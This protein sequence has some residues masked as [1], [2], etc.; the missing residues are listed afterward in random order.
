M[1]FTPEMKAWVTDAKAR[2]SLAIGQELDQSIR[3]TLMLSSFLGHPKFFY[4]NPKL[5]VITLKK[6][7]VWLKDPR[8]T[9]AFAKMCAHFLKT[10]IHTAPP[11]Q[12]SLIDRE[13][14]R[15]CDLVIRIFG[16][17]PQA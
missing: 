1:E 14:L 9:P 4:G 2:T 8:A 6:V 10:V 7:L 12:F 17:G 3:W 5:F 16:H 15:E 11:S 13:T